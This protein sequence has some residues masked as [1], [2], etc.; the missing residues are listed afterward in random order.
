MKQINRLHLMQ[1]ILS[2]KVTLLEPKC[3]IYHFVEQ[4][5]AHRMVYRKLR[6]HQGMTILESIYRLMAG[7]VLVNVMAAVSQQINLW[8]VLFKTDF[9]RT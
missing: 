2:D 1:R 5:A 9:N 4:L 7:I 6:F 3:H 8:K